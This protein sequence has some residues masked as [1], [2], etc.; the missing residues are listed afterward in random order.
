MSKTKVYKAASRLGFV[1]PPVLLVVLLVI[2]CMNI[3][4]TEGYFIVFCTLIVP[5]IATTVFG[6]MMI[7]KPYPSIPLLKSM[8][9]S[10]KAFFGLLVAFLAFAAL[11]TGDKDQDI[12]QA[13]LVT[14]LLF[15]VVISVVYFVAV[16]AV[17]Q[18][19]EL[20]EPRQIR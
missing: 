19:D 12:L 17:H 13:A 1:I 7:R 5:L 11:F 16:Y 9:D 2:F 18:A 6:F 3:I 15:G 14:L 4:S 20:N 10:L 8:L